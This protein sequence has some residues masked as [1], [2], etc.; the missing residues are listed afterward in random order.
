MLMS[1]TRFSRAFRCGMAC[2]VV[3]AAGCTTVGP[4]YERPE[5]TTADDWLE[6]NDARVDTASVE[7]QDWW[8]VFNDPVLDQLI[9][10]AYQQNLGLQVA[11][12]RVLQ[13][14]AQLGI[15]V[16]LQYP[17]SQS[18]SAGYVRSRASQNAPPLANL[19]DD[20]ASRASTGLNT[21]STSFDAAWEADV[22]GKFRRGIQAADANLAANMLNYD[23]LLV[24]LT[25]DVAALYSVIRTYEERLEV[26]RQNVQL[27]TEALNLAQTRFD[28]GATSQLDVEQSTSLLR[29]TQ[30]LIPALELGLGR[31]K[32]TL[33][34]L[35]GMPPSDLQAILGGAGNIP[36]APTTA[37][38]GI[39]ADLLRRRPDVR[40]AEMAAATQSAA[41]GVSAAD[42]YPHFVIAGSLGL[43]GESFSD[44]FKSG[45]ATAFLT[46]FVSWDILNYGRIKN[47]VRVQ[48]A[49]FEQL[50]VSYQNSVLNAA[51]EVQDGLL[52]FL[53][54]QEQIEF[55]A[56]GVEASVRAADLALVQYQQGAVDYTRV[57]NTQTTL[58]QQQDALTASRGA[59]VTNLIAVYKALGGGW[60]LRE[61]NNFVDE[62]LREK[63]AARTDW[64]ALLDSTAKP[65]QGE[66]Q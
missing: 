4:D 1:G 32:N 33:S 9:T 20:V 42:L 45:S 48:D 50:A 11:G 3:I 28:L 13:A 62:A 57:L 14:R 37:A 65:E 55:L 43:A 17:Q 31:T 24:T 59:V 7:Y 58:L 36:T 18:V 39:P 23:A 63:M 19:P 27:Q 47:N 26:A 54:T 66:V 60:Q 41:I 51:R 29:N 56:G 61:G 5:T 2:S 21:W 35:L 10:Q 40:A 16:G 49:R 12:L 53:R 38:V 8:S 6:A 52:G 25:G 46:P 22:W 30:A 64:D 44:Q 34:F 15:A